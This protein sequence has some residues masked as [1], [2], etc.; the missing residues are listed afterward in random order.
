[1]IYSCQ[2]LNML[3]IG[4]LMNNAGLKSI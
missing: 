3:I 4:K 1:M 2:I